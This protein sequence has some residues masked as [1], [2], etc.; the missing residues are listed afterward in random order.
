M[1]LSPSSGGVVGD[2]W[3]QILEAEIISR[4]E[5]KIRIEKENFFLEKNDFEKFEIE[6]KNR[7]FQLFH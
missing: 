3:A 6:K 7:K 2:L 1:D 4:P 5:K